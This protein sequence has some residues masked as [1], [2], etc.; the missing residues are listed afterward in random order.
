[1]VE[2][3]LTT[4]PEIPCPCL[5]AIE[6]GGGIPKTGQTISYAT[7]DDG[8]LQKGFAWPYPRFTDNG[9]GTVTDELTSQ[10]WLKD[11]GCLGPRKW[12][13][14]LSDANGLADGSCGLTDGSSAGDWRLP[15]R[16]ELL[17]LVDIGNQNPA[18]RQIYSVIVRWVMKF[19]GVPYPGCAGN[20]VHNIL[21]A[22]Q[23]VKRMRYRPVSGDRNR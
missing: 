9:D 3:L 13:E 1:M 19:P 2:V 7:G 16:F 5:E 4:C 12:I 14:A 6:G 11:A 22:L 18:A 21:W 23:T 15:N 10:I 8:D 20:G 17:V